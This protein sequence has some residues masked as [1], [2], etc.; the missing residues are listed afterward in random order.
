MAF[1]NNMTRILN[2]IEVRLGVKLLNLPDSI[3]KDTWADW[4]YTTTLT[5]FS[6]YYPNIVPYI[7]DTSKM[8]RDAEGYYLIDE[9]IFPSEIEIIGCQDIPWTDPTAFGVNGCGMGGF[10][11]AYSSPFGVMDSLF[12]YGYGEIAD[13]QAGADYNSLFSNGIYI[14]FKS[15][16]RLKLVDVSGSYNNFRTGTFK[17]NLLIKHAKNLQT[18]EPTK[19]SIFEDLATCDVAEYLYSNLKYYDEIDTVFTNTSLR[20][21]DLR[22]FV[23]KRQEI[24]DKLEENYVAADNFNQPI[25]YT[26]N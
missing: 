7:F 19:M 11:Q 3:N 18:I 12:Q 14:D 24:I 21:D 16:N 4:I 6:R 2:I 13:I 8:K 20:L 9:N 10:N 23:D 17:V 5:T 25:M 1:S 26:I 22:N 15:P